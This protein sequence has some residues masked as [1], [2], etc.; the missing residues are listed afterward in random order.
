MDDARPKPIAAAATAHDDRRATAAL[1]MATRQRE[2][3]REREAFCSVCRAAKIAAATSHA[4]PA[5]LCSGTRCR[6]PR[7]ET[8]CVHC[9]VYQV[10]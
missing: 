5:R 7:A 8:K 6:P 4:L 10:E 3:E 2:R 1:S 9:T